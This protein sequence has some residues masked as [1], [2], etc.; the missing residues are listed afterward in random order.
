MECI[1]LIL[2]PV[3]NKYHINLLTGCTEGGR[4]QPKLRYQPVTPH[5]A[6]YKNATT[7]YM[8]RVENPY[9]RTLSISVLSE[10]GDSGEIRSNY[11]VQVQCYHSILSNITGILHHWKV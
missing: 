5:P 1:V 4:A 11:I 9:I 2:A 3:A 7:T 8:R 6:E 10:I